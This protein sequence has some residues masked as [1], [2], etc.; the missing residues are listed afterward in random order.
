MRDFYHDLE[1][2]SPREY[3][4][5]CLKEAPGFTADLMKKNRIR[6]A[7]VKNFKDRE[8]VTM[9]RPVVDE[10]KLAH[11][12]SIN[13]DSD[14]LKPEFKRQVTSFVNLVG[15]K[16]RPKMVAGKILNPSMFL[17]L[18]LE[19]TESLSSKEAPVIM[20]ALDRVVQAETVKIM[21]ENYEAVRHRIIEGEELAEEHLP[22][23]AHDLK[24]ALK[25]IIR[26]ARSKTERELAQVLSFKEI[27]SDEVIG[28]FLKRV[29]ELKI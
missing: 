17:Q 26:D 19:Y 10:H 22:M 5:E 3:L 18:A 23:N 27:Q 1:G 21:D 16:L 2:K 15:K 20:T 14:V 9:I 4:E 13:W 25:R 24:K 29:Q 11:V 12:E 7:I 6:N 8:A 28:K